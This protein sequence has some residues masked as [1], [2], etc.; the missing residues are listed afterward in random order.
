MENIINMYSEIKNIKIKGEQDEIE[1]LYFDKLKEIVGKYNCE[2]NLYDFDYERVYRKDYEVLD[3]WNDAY[4]FSVSH[5]LCET[6]D[7]DIW[8]LEVEVTEMVMINV[9]M[10]FAEASEKWELDDSTLRKLVTT[11]KLAEGTDYRKSG[12]VWLITKEAM[13]KVYGYPKVKSF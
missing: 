5:T 6:D 7:E 2:V 4:L 3:N 10:T 8:E 1:E 12:K 13:I 11:N 9:V